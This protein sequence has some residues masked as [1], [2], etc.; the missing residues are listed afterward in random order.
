MDSVRYERPQERN[1]KGCIVYLVGAPVLAL[2]LWLPWS[3]LLTW[4]LP[5][6]GIPL[7][8]AS[9]LSVTYLLIIFAAVCRSL[10]REYTSRKV[11][12]VVS[13]DRIQLDLPGDHAT[14]MIDAIESIRLRSCVGKLQVLLCQGPTKTHALP[15]DIA[16]FS[17]VRDG[18]EKLVIPPLV[19]RIE[20]RVQTGGE[21]LIGDSA[22]LGLLRIL[23]ALLLIPIGL[24]GVA[25]LGFLGTGLGLLSSVPGRIRRGW[26]G[27]GG[28]LVLR[29]GGLSPV[30]GVVRKTISWEELKILARDEHGLVLSSR[31]G[32]TLAI[33]SHADNF[34]P[35]SRWIADRLSRPPA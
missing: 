16:A 2:I 32:G 34:W 19:A 23:W 3:A 14:V 8:T 29:N 10:W 27:L 6:L 28:G 21:I 15:T 22:V 31:R 7:S 11:S 5:K 20:E 1:R 9:D 30:S 17:L 24:V 13:S 25:S 4:L 18:Y 26:R 12:V 33:S 35:A